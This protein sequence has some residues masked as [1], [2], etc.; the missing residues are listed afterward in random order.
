MIK[1][2]KNT[3]TT[4]SV[5]NEIPTPTTTEVFAEIMSI[6]QTEFFQASTTGL[7][8]QLKVIIWEFDYDGETDVEVEAKIYVV[9]RTFL[10]N[11]QKMELYLTA[12]VGV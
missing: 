7:K 2:I 3:I 6:S 5:G 10:A 11:E 8:P 4:D 9:Y 1:L 12:K